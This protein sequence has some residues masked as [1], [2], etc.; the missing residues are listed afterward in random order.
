MEV[1]SEEKI[2]NGVKSVRA[3]ALN[4]GVCFTIAGVYTKYCTTIPTD[5]RLCLSIF[6]CCVIWSVSTSFLYGFKKKL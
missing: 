6:V 5:P 1:M 3:D 2:I 4:M